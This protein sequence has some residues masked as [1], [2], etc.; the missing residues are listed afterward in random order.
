MSK[1]E[2]PTLVPELRFPE[3][4][5]QDGWKPKILEE[6]CDLQ[7]GKFVKAANIKSEKDDSLYPCYGG[8]G[9]RGFTES[10][11]HNGNYSLIGRQG[12]LC[13][14]INFVSGKFHATEHAV[15]VEPKRGI[16]NLWLYY[17][18]C[19]LNLNRFAT[20]Q[21]QPGLSVD[22][23]YKVDACVPVVGKEQQKIA[24]C[25]SSM[26]DLIKKNTKKLDSLKLHKKGLMQ[27]LFPEEGKNVP[28]LRFSDFNEGWKEKN[29]G[30]VCYL[31]AGKFVK[32]VNIKSKKNDRLYPCYGGNG[33]R[34]F[35]ESFTHEGSYSLI[36]RQ[37]AL[38]GNV[39]FVS[40]RFYATEHAVVVEPKENIDNLWLYYDLCRLNL[41]RF[42]TG[43][44]Q[45]GLSVDNL[46]RV[47]TCI[48]KLKKEQ[49]KIADCL[50][51]L[52]KLIK[53]QSKKVDVL[54]EYKKGLMQRLFPSVE[55]V[56]V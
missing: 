54:K 1:I 15:V 10:F 41:N 20:G 56:I 37:G 22:N 18:L 7:A 16:D 36:G 3:F 14:N 34:G 47:D 5:E 46:N 9:L 35:T 27:K 45:P 42:A 4:V 23:L 51:T 33:L 13:G 28:E 39:N 17:E 44:A 55:G 30:S 29:V 50:Y 2:Y 11:T 52:D 12:A 26:D 31:Q 32:A 38:C 53:N 40:G 19:R 48:P 8:N 43:Q 25:L 24:D 6:V 49:Q 21:A